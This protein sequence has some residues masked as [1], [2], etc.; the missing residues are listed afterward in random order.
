MELGGVAF[1]GGNRSPG[2]L[3]EEQVGVAS[4][5]DGGTRQRVTGTQETRAKHS[6]WPG[7]AHPSCCLGLAWKGL[8]GP[9]P[10]GKGGLEPSLLSALPSTICLSS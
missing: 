5:G 7:P 2:G 3:S 10:E 9:G 4:R 1:T 8:L 6:L